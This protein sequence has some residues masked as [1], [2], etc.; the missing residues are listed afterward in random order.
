[1]TSGLTIKGF[2]LGNLF[3]FPVREGVCACENCVMELSMAE[4]ND[5]SHV[6]DKR[7]LYNEIKSCIEKRNMCYNVLYIIIYNVLY[8]IKNH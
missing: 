3:S 2:F 7:Q 8:I 6:E 1:M 5:K 4:T